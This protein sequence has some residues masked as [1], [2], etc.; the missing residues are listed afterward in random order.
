VLVKT[1]EINDLTNR[2]QL[3]WTI[4]DLDLSRIN[5]LNH[6]NALTDSIGCFDIDRVNRLILVGFELKLTVIGFNAVTVW[7]W[8]TLGIDDSMERQQLEIYV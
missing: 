8:N 3:Q 6:Q 4:N 5:D 1:D 7:A 2:Q